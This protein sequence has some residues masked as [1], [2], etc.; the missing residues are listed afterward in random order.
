MPELP[1][2]TI[3]VEALR[4]R[5]VGKRLERIRVK[6]PFLLRTFEPP[7]ESVADARVHSVD[8]MGKRIVLGLSDHLYAVLHLMIAGRLLWYPAPGSTDV[9]SKGAGRTPLSAKIDLAAFEFET[10]T[11]LLTEA[12]TKKRASL[13]LVKGKEALDALDPGGVEPLTCTTEEFGAALRRENRTLKR[14]LT[15]PHIVSGIGNAYSDEILFRCRLSPF[16]LTRSLTDDEIGAL[17]LGAAT[18]LG[19]WTDS[20]RVQFGM[21]RAGH[22]AGRDDPP[23]GSIGRFPGVGEITAFRPDFRVHGKYRQ[24]CWMCETPI[25]RVVYAENEMNYCPTCQT[26]GK[27]LADRSLSRLL[28]DDWPRTVEELEHA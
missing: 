15:D 16:R 10:G 6:S 12:G 3:Y 28:K 25:Q 27:V 20:L 24:P 21:P 11:L 14:A 13:H 5:V 9:K 2:I 22:G 7:V 8:R 4:P 18:S 1:D 23:R 17:L 26:G 19:E